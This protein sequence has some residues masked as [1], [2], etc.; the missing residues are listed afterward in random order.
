M[1]LHLLKTWQQAR[2]TFSPHY[3]GQYN[4][5]FLALFFLVGYGIFQSPLPGSIQWNAVVKVLPADLFRLSVPITW[6]NTMKPHQNAKKG[7]GWYTFSPHYLGQY[8]ET[9]ILSMESMSAFIFQSPLPGSIQWNSNNSFAN[10]NDT[11]TFSP[12]YLGQYNETDFVVDNLIILSYSFSPHY[13][14]QYNET[15]MEHCSDDIKA[16]LSVPITWVNTMKLTI[17]KT[18]SLS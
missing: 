11:Q 8:N 10:G 9:I 15:A 1:K 12:H 13:L 7:K 5:T 17:I 6:V 4:E 18:G 3:L 14:G 2:W 16:F